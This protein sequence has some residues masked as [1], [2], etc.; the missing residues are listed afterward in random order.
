MSYVNWNFRR[1]VLLLII[2]ITDL[3]EFM[4]HDNTSLVKFVKSIQILFFQK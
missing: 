1:N 2:N 4:T 3:D